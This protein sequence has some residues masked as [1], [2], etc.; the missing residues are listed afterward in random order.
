LKG[1]ESFHQISNG[2]LLLQDSICRSRLS[3]FGFQQFHREPFEKKKGKVGL[4]GSEKR[5]N[6]TKQNKTKQNKTNNK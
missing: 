3:F 6:K 1:K 5:K 4:E 2:Q